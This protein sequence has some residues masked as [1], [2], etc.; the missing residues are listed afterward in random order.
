[1]KRFSLLFA[2]TLAAC[3]S[4][5]EPVTTGPR[6]LAQLA[7]RFRDSDAPGRG[8]DFSPDGNMLATSSASGLVV[9]RHLP[10]LKI[11][12]RL[13]HPGGATAIA[14]AP[15]GEWLATSG[16]DGAVRLW[17][18]A[19]GR[20]LRA[21]EGARGTVWTLDVSPRGDRL[22]AAG[23]DGLVRI[24][25]PADGRLLARLAGHK[26]NIWEVRFS[27]DGKRLASGSFDATARLWDSATGKALAILAEHEQAVVGIAWSPDGRWLATG[28]DDSTILIRR[29]SDGAPVRR[30][31]VG[32]HAYKLGFSPDSR[33]LVNAG[34]ARGGLGTLWHGMTGAG[35]GGEPVR[36]WR[37]AD[38]ALV[39][40]LSLPED[41]MSV[42]ISPDGRWLVASADDGMITVWRLQ[43]GTS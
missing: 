30:L 41:I 13:D 37:V 27:P 25:N 1:M 5:P 14:F 19:G 7:A 9:L 23:E 12:R 20:P 28:G 6:L 33:W 26:R 11:V 38:G 36:L 15:G 8:A 10:D 22:A 16:Y 31:D 42:D 39:Q 18:I 29:A 24:W 2:I 40:A 4:A 32:N 21:L 34:R 3:G 43:V 17:D 35:G